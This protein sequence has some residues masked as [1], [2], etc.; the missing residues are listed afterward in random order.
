M[1]EQFSRAD[2]GRLRVIGVSFQDINSDSVAFVKRLHLTF[3]A[4]LDDPDGPVGTRYGVRG[5]PQTVFVDPDGIV[6][7]RVF[8]QTSRKD[9]LPAIA[10]LLAGRNIRPV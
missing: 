8:G 10:D 4:L 5:L 3:P 6:R 1:L 9:L 7:G 2:A